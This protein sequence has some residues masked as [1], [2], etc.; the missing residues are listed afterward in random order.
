M[1]LKKIKRK[2]KNPLYFPLVRGI[3]KGDKILPEELKLNE[4]MIIDI[5]LFCKKISEKRCAGNPKRAG[6]SVI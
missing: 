3:E 6:K 5:F 4:M 1:R 2:E